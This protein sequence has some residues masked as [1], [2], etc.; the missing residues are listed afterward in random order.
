[1]KTTT[2]KNAFKDIEKG[3]NFILIE[4]PSILKS[5]F[6]KAIPKNSTQIL[7]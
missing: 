1:M 2:Q 4:Y 7:I 6:I 5:I 3:L